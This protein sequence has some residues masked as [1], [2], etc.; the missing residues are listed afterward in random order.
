MTFNGSSFDIPF[1]RKRYDILPDIPHIDL[2]HLCARLG[3][4]GGLKEIEKDFGFFRN[5]II[6]KFHG[7]DALTLWR[8]YKATGEKYYLDLLVEYNEDDCFNL[9]KI[10]NYC[11]QKMKETIYEKDLEVI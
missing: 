9:K 2:R 10:M 6:E 3:M 7:G 5:K 8:M 4:T 11:Y 1:I